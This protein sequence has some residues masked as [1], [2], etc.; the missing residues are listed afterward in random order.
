MKK[1]RS[2]LAAGLSAAAMAASLMSVVPASASY[3]IS[4]DMFSAELFVMGNQT[5]MYSSS[6][7]SSFDGSGTLCITGNAEDIANGAGDEAIGTAGIAL[8]CNY[9]FTAGCAEEIIFE[10]DYA[11]TD[12]NGSVVITDTTSFCFNENEKT[13]SIELFPYNTDWATFRSLGIFTL[14]MHI[15]S[16]TLN[17]PENDRIYADGGST[18]GSETVNYDELRNVHF[19]A[20]DGTWFNMAYAK[21]GYKADISGASTVIEIT[22]DEEIAE[23]TEILK[24][25]DLSENSVFSY[26]APYTGTQFTYEIPLEELFNATDSDGN[27][28]FDK[29]TVELDGYFGC[30]MMMMTAGTISGYTTGITYNAIDESVPDSS[31]A[32]DSSSGGSGK[33]EDIKKLPWYQ[34]TAV[35]EPLTLFSDWNGNYSDPIATK[36]LI[37]G[38]SWN[39][40]WMQF[41][42]SDLDFDGMYVTFTVDASQA[43]WDI[44]S[45]SGENVYDNGKYTVLQ[46][47]ALD[48]Y[49]AAYDGHEPSGLLDVTEESDKVYTVTVSG[50][51]LEKAYKEGTLIAQPMTISHGYSCYCIGFNAQFGSFSNAV[52]SASVTGNTVLPA[53]VNGSDVTFPSDIYE[54]SDHEFSYYETQEPTCTKPGLNTY[55]C[56][57]GYSYSEEIPT[58][59]H[60]YTS[61]WVI[62]KFPTCKEN[63]EVSKHCKVCDERTEIVPLAKTAHAY[64]E[65]IVTKESTETALGEIKYTCAY[66]GET[67]TEKAD[68]KKLEN[69]QIT[70]SKTSLYFNGSEIKPTVKAVYGG[71]TLV[72]DRDYSVEYKENINAGTASVTVTGTGIYKGT[73]EKEFTILPRSISNCTVEYTKVMNYTGSELIPDVTVL[74]GGTDVSGFCEIS[75]ENNIE[76]GTATLILNGTGSLK[77]TLRKT[78]TID[79]ASINDYEIKLSSENVYFNGQRLKPTVKLMKDGVELDNSNYTVTYSDNLSTGTASVTVTGKGNFIGTVVKTY[80]IRQRSI[81]NC[82]IT[83]TE[84]PDNKNQPLV[85]VNVNGTSIYNGNYTV[86]YS[87]VSA[88]GKVRVTIRGSRN[89]WDTAV[90]V[91]K[92]S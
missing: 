12:S 89:L 44:D 41:Y 1:I 16:I 62:D 59:G 82:K 58:T 36:D 15:Q 55:Y 86:E 51:I 63:G 10:C 42:T 37:T 39:G 57:C 67:R 34:E 33:D 18:W 68:V 45:E 43:E 4:P 30:N 73:V 61:F 53:E 90:K 27:M 76:K 40:G 88:D 2:R 20:Y 81:K 70:L 29:E 46:F 31:A 9:G 23:G 54:G 17:Q 92:V 77:G 80:T 24:F 47:G 78:F 13:T 5:W 22:T 32:D 66:C 8:Q 26:A 6:G 7:Q 25:A 74:S 75:C 79:S 71:K 84:N 69:A 35:E 72:K 28:L 52:F 11:L 3:D 38:G 48:S 87:D 85:S 64:D 50:D 14:T 60:D 19:N 91:Y 83:L 21:E 56:D 65:G 49:N